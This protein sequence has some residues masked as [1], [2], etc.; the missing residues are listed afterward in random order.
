MT[1]SRPVPYASVIIA[2]YNEEATLGAQLEA[3]S[4]ERSAQP[5]EILVCD[6]GSDDGTVAVVQRMT[7][8]VPNLR[9]IDAS[10]RRG[11]G[12][13]RNIGASAARGELLL[14]CDADDVVEPGWVDALC[15]AAANAD[16]VAGT[17]EGRL[18]NQDHQAAVS[19]EVSSEITVAWWPRYPAGAT[20][21]MAVRASAF[22]AVGG[23]DETLRTGEDID[24]CWRIQIAGYAFA[25]STE[26]VV[27]SRQRQGR[28][29]VFRQAFSYGAGH[30]ALRVKYRQHVAAQ[31]LISETPTP[32]ASESEGRVAHRPPPRHEAQPD[33][34]SPRPSRSLAARARRAVLTPAGHANVAWRLGEWLGGR[35]GRIHPQI[36]ATP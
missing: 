28:R 1:A 22:H 4:Q 16:L 2:A 13:A 17:L 35:F 20:S 15:D 26:A 32:E 9:L 33:S 21:N 7:A 12:A 27:H 10:A 14:F 18:L 36:A 25:R 19:W 30:R 6:N 8:S 23:F 5:F 29:A 34:A 11:P 3:L 31:T 24:L